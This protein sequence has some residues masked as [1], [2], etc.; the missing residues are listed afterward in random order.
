[1]YLLIT[2]IG[3]TGGNEAVTPF[4][5]KENNEIKETGKC[6]YAILSTN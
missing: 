1:M 6:Y 3:S 4:F 5:F 2:I